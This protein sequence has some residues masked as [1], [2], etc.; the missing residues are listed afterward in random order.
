MNDTKLESL[1]TRELEVL[2]K[3][4]DGLSYKMIADGLGISYGTVNNHIK[5]YMKNCKFIP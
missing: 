5:K 1:T 2:H 3:L 4:A